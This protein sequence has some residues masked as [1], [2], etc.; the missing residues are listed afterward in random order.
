M[1]RQK[2]AEENKDQF[3]FSLQ[4]SQEPTKCPKGLPVGRWPRG[5]EWVQATFSS[6]TSFHVGFQISSSTY[7]YRHGS[8]L[9]GG[10]PLFLT[11]HLLVSIPFFHSP[12]NILK[13]SPPG[14]RTMVH[15]VGIHCLA[16]IQPRFNPWNPKW[17]STIARV[18]SWVTPE[19]VWVSPKT[20]SHVK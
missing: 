11:N 5:I 7:S 8:V 2:V 15:W 18:Q 16:E 1:C 19:H 14:V 6:L 17:S 12:W 13:F 4:T 10:L 20:K 3:H 9:L